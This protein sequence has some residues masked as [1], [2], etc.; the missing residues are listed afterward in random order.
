VPLP[1]DDPLRGGAGDGVDA[2][3]ERR[4][5]RGLPWAASTE[6]PASAPVAVTLSGGAETFEFGHGLTDPATLRVYGLLP[7]YDTGDDQAE[8]HVD[9]S[10]PFTRLREGTYEATF[11]VIAERY[12]RVAGDVDAEVAPDAAVGGFVPV[13]HGLSAPPTVVEATRVE[14]S[15][16]RRVSAQTEVRP[17]D[18]KVVWVKA[19]SSITLAGARVHLRAR[20]G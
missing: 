18:E 5:Q 1:R 13:V 20:V 8:L 17:A 2:R 11:D 12:G 16:H 4:R 15:N 10:D 6:A 3:R 14:T 7:V 9:R 19:P